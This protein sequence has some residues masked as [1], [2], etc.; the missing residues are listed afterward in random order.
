[1]S[2]RDIETVLLNGVTYAKDSR[3]FLI[4]I[5]EGAAEGEGEGGEGAGGT[6]GDDGD[7]SDDG[8]AGGG[9]DDK[10]GSDDKGGEE[11]VS[12]DEFNKVMDRMKA[13]DRRADAAERKVRDFEDKD[14]DKN[15]V[16]E[17]DLS[18]ATEKV[19]S[20]ESR[21]L[22]LNLENAIMA[23]ASG[24]FHDLRDVVSN[25]DIDDVTDDDGE[26]DKKALKKAVDSLAKSKPYLLVE[27]S[28]NG[29]GDGDEEDGDEDE[30]SGSPSGTP[31]NKDKGKG[32]GIDKAYLAK[33]YP[34]LRR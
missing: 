13:A 6:E 19:S 34:A 2:Q 26:V 30:G 5:P 18:E 8:S 22:T 10:G 20:L 16:L 15:E 11:P 1:M 21:V 31:Q 28:K 23:E 7:E 9:D 25:I 33:K 17:R 32:K 24:R 3:G 12:R 14:K 4:P 29:D 27:S